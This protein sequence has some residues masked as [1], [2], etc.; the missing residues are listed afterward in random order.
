MSATEDEKDAAFEA[1]RQSAFRTILWTIAAELHGDEK[2]VACAIA[3]LIDV[4]TA[5]RELGDDLG[6]EPWPDDL[7][8]GDVVNKRIRRE[9]EGMLDDE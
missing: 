4:R 3:E 1:G 7:H 5:L 2:K 8:L 6:C 9:I